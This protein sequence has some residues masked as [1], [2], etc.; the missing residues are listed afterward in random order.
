MT[1][2][3]TRYAIFRPA[4]WGILAAL[5]VALPLTSWGQE[6]LRINTASLPPYAQEDRQGFL[7][8][9]IAEAF[10]RI[11]LQ[12][13]INRYV[14]ASARGF[15]NANLGVDDGEA[16]RI[17]GL[18]H[19]YPN[20]IQVPEPIKTNNFVGYTL[21][22]R[23]PINNFMEL[24]SYNVGYII[25]WIIFQK[26]LVPNQTATAI[27]SPE[28]MYQ[29]LDLNRIDVALY[30]EWQG[31]YI[32]RQMGLNLL[33]LDPPLVQTEM[34]MYLH[35]RHRE[36]VPLVAQ[37]LADMKA[38]GSYQRIVDQTLTPLRN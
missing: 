7:D 14:G 15:E 2:K 23:P 27:K 26:N 9:L 24:S 30:E 20:L 28:Q 4:R 29:M 17:A 18:S 16:L 25:G 11:G 38:D 33:V 34:F 13:Q 32:G 35:Q 19:R 31:L 10:A 8:L 5:L 36:L 22:T 6:P 1:N 3:H 37:A 12:A 21:G